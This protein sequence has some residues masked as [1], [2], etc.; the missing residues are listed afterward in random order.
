MDG[1]NRD[2]DPGRRWSSLVLIVGGVAIVLVV[3]G[4]WS[5]SMAMESSIAETK[6]ALEAGL[7]TV[8]SAEC[9]VKLWANP[10][11]LVDRDPP[12]YFSRG[13]GRRT[14]MVDRIIKPSIV[15]R[16]ATRLTANESPECPWGY[17][18]SDSPLPFIVRT[19]YG[20]FPGG[21]SL[22][23]DGIPLGSAEGV[24]TYFSI[25]GLKLYL[26][27]W[28]VRSHVT[29]PPAATEDAP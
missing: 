11:D 16:D 23:A 7:P 4:L 9:G 24:R 20:V 6:L 2:T 13:P 17:V 3:I 21:G 19:T 8:G 12:G 22:D 28:G 18:V 1:R 10:E 5:A 15:Y 14:S 29:P 25:F 27:E 26:N